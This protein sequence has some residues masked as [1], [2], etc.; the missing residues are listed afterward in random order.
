MRACGFDEEASLIAEIYPACARVGQLANDYHDMHGPE[1]YR[2]INNGVSSFYVTALRQ[3][4]GERDSR[5]IF[6]M[7]SEELDKAISAAGIEEIMRAEA[8]REVRHIYSEINSSTLSQDRKTVLTAWAYVQ[9]ANPLAS[10]EKL[11]FVPSVSHL[12]EAVD[13]LTRKIK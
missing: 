6:R 10:T 5:P 9:L 11:P 12:V 2:D 4:L 8:A 3:H 7:S 1:R 13:N